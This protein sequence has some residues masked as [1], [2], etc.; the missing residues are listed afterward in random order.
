MADGDLATKAPESD[1]TASER[2]PG[3][4]SVIPGDSLAQQ[5]PSMGDHCTTDR[6]TPAGEL[7]TGELTKIGDVDVYITKP[8]DYPHAPSKLLLLLTGGTGIH[9][10]NN[11]LQAD[12]Y[13]G[14]GFLVVMPDQFS[15]DPAPNSTTLVSPTEN[16]SFLESV[17]LR[18]AETG[19]SFMI[20]M[21]LARQTPEKVMPILHK[22]IEG[23][24]EEFADAI[25]NGGG[26]Y[27]A[28]YCFGGKYVLLLAGEQSDVGQVSKD[29]E[30]GV[31]KPGPYIKAGAIAHG[32][33]VTR[34]D[35][36]GVKVPVSVVA[37]EDDSLFPPEILQAGKEFLKANSVEHEIETFTGVPHGFAVLGD[38]DDA[39][40]KDAQQ[41]AFGQMLGWI[42]RF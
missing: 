13:A 2:N 25:A 27:A 16:V 41:R 33:M 4:E 20:D 1:A 11:Q 7:P 31:T 9:S 10:T 26:I 24:K 6:P 21:W 38:Y 34:E 12:K 8:A 29:E 3:A 32:T 18:V 19:K 42:Q 28:G 5:G 15:G 39:K 17:K 30:Q 35:L 14:E 40:I 23:A 37:V 36:A 22:V